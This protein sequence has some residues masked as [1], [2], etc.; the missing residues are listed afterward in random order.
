[1]FSDL[2]KFPKY[3]QKCYQIFK[4][5]TKSSKILPNLKKYSKIFKNIQKYYITVGLMGTL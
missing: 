4:N 5:I 3:L 2:K 1:M